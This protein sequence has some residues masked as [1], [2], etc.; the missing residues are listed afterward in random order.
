[1]AGGEGE[2]VG[3][4]F[5]HGGSVMRKASAF[6]MVDRC[7]SD[8]EKRISLYERSFCIVLIREMLISNLGQ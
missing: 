1:M 5:W 3:R 6:I 8:E 2:A 7:C 4:Y